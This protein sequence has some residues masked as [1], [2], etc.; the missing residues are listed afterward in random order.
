MTSLA[1]RGPLRRW[2]AVVHRWTGLAVMA[3]LLVAS[4]TGSWL[5]F[6][7]EID[8]WLNPG[9]RIVAPG[10]ARLSLAE[11]AS[12]VEVRFPDARAST[13]MLP[14]GP[15][16]AIGVYLRPAGTTPLDVDQVFVN[17][18]TGA[19]LGARSTSRAVLSKACLD[20]VVMRVH[21]S[22]LLGGWGLT[23]M[24]TCAALWLATS[25]VGVALAWPGAWTRG[26]SWV[27]VLSAETTRGAY[28]A[29]YQLHRAVGWWL[30]PV[31]VVLAFT[32]VY[33]NLPQY[34]VPVVAAFSPLT[35]VPAGGEP[36]P[37][38]DVR[39]SQDAALASLRALLPEARPSSVLR[40]LGRGRHSI[41]F[42][43]P[44]DVSPQGDNFAF[45]DLRTGAVTAVRRPGTAT[46][47][48]RFLRWL[49]PLHT[50][51]AFGWPGRVLV[52]ISGVAVAF[53][54]ASGFYVWWVKWR[55][56]RRAAGVDGASSSGFR[57]RSGVS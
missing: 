18:Y 36:V 8:R 57:L 51:A 24:G 55:M 17:P 34:V 47:G 48:D 5:A 21:Y 32:S 56:R 54:N 11:I 40:D 49:Y 52:G 35:P 45:V 53:L 41:L 12:R 38:D 2:M 44:G 4:V 3:G 28:R 23:L 39:V 7:T 30:L 6:R 29:N 9:L 15:T 16:D 19:I 33:L 42:H 26:R 20:P 22:L 10:P 13:L 25:L 43:L 31:L 1:L 46:A 14:E 50:G 37:E 27:P